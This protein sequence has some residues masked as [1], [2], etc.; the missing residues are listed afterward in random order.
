MYADT[1]DDMADVE[2]RK[3]IPGR[4]HW[5]FDALHEGK[6]YKLCFCWVLPKDEIPFLRAMEEYEHRIEQ[7]HPEVIGAIKDVLGDFYE[8]GKV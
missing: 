4:V 3:H 2:I 5:E 1:Q 8:K 6:G 7:Y